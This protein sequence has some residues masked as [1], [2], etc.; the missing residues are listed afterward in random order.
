MGY[1]YPTNDGPKTEENYS[2]ESRW[3]RNVSCETLYSEM[4]ICN[5][6]ELGGRIVQTQEKN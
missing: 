5:P 1:K 3:K 4:C 2:T 6:K